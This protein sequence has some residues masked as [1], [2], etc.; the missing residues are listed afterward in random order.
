MVTITNIICMRDENY[1]LYP[2]YART[3]YIKPNS[4]THNNYC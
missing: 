1:I 3:H 2:V 4:K